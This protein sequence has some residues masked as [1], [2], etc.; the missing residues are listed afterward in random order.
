MGKKIWFSACASD[1]AD[2]R[3]CGSHIPVRP[4]ARPPV[5]TSQDNQYV[6][7]ACNLC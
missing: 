4:S 3:N 6:V 7:R 1:S 2:P 5:R